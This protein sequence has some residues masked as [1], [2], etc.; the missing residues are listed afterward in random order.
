MSLF[1]LGINDFIVIPIVRHGAMRAIFD[2]L[3]ATGVFKIPAT[4]ITQEIERAIAEQAVELFGGKVFMARK[5]LALDISKK[6]VT[7]VHDAIYQSKI[8]SQ[9]PRRSQR[10]RP[11][12]LRCRIKAQID[13]EHG[14]TTADQGDDFELIPIGKCHFVIFGI[15][16]HVAVV[17]NGNIF[18]LEVNRLKQF[19]DCHRGRECPSFTIDRQLHKIVHSIQSRVHQIPLSTPN[20][21]FKCLHVA[22]GSC[23]S[24]TT[25]C[26][27]TRRR[28][29]SITCE[30]LSK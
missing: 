6:L 2:F 24:V 16:N 15:G 14:S 22:A 17:L 20:F 8:H 13:I 5:I 27:A 30:R 29:E 12:L 9:F 3:R 1:Q 19:R 25:D 28:P 10:D 11:A 4:L 18:P 26:T 21:S 7:V 23:D